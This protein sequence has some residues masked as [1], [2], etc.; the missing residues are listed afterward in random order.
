MHS[1][2][3]GFTLVELSIVLVI[4]GL[5]VGGVLSGQS[6]IRASELR[7]VSREQAQYQTALHA[8]RD[9]Y[10]ALPGDMPNAVRFWGAVDGPLTDG[11][12][13]DCIAASLAADAVDPQTCNGDGNGIWAAHETYFGWEH[14]ANGGLIEG[15]YTASDAGSI[16]F[17]R[18]APRSTLGNNSGWSFRYFDGTGDVLSDPVENSMILGAAGNVP[19]PGWAPV[20]LPEEAFNLDKK[21]DDGLP[22]QGRLL[23]WE[24]GDLADTEDRG[25]C[26]NAAGNAY[27]LT[28]TQT[29]CA[30]V[31]LLK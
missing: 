18:S 26:A 17:G 29:A 3:H 10:F 28:Y 7:A 19:S 6:L 11:D 2:R 15:Q 8:F 27:Q 24:P 25:Q 4:L 20:L 22:H 31:F 1:P 30:L 12:N 23:T 14:L 16:I 9:K 21:M 5:L 13:G